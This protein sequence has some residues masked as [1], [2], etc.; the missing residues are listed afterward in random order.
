MRCDVDNRMVI[1]EYYDDEPEPDELPEL[2]FEAFDRMLMEA[3]ANA[4]R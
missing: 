4:M 1:G 3:L 2:P